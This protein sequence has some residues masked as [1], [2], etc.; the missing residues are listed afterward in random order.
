MN[1]VVHHSTVRHVPRR[2]T[3]R[4]IVGLP[5]A[6]VASVPPCRRKSPARR[7]PS[8]TIGELIWAGCDYLIDVVQRALETQEKRRG[9]SGS[10]IC[11]Q[12]RAFLLSLRPSLMNSTRFMSHS[13]RHFLKRAEDPGSK[14]TSTL[15]VP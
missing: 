3:K 4:Q 9:E 14:L 8:T 11:V 13:N 2:S 5:P 10:V 12:V 1:V 6:I 15:Y 7:R